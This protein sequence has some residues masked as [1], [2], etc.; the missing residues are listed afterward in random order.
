MA[1]QKLGQL[2]HNQKSLVIKAVHAVTK[3]GQLAYDPLKSSIL[4]PYILLDKW[5]NAFS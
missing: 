1:P 3:F 4:K 2:T 5:D